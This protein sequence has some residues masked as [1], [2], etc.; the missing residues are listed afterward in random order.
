MTTTDELNC[1]FCGNH[2]GDDSMMDDNGAI[3]CRTC[4]SA[5]IAAQNTERRL[6]KLADLGFGDAADFASECATFKCSQ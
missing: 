1:I 5:E 6:K 3:A 2:T 4:G